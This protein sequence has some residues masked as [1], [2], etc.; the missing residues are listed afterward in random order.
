MLVGIYLY[1]SIPTLSWTGRCCCGGWLCACCAGSVRQ[2][3]VCMHWSI[4]SHAYTG[5]R[6]SLSAGNSVHGR[7]RVR[8]SMEPYLQ[9]QWW[10]YRDDLFGRSRFAAPARLVAVQLG[11]HMRI[12]RILYTLV[13]S[14]YA[15]QTNIH[16]LC[17]R[18]W[19]TP[20]GCFSP[21]ID[22][23]CVHGYLLSLLTRRVFSAMQISSC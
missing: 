16:C 7:R 19:S 15:N 14:C 13:Q 11:C 21:W 18:C 6:N 20:S 1:L 9:G 22:G 4:K 10:L 12:H 8:R 23:T 5:R 17:C 3:C 2:H